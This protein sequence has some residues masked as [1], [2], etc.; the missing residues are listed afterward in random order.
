MFCV[1]R[2]WP[3]LLNEFY[4]PLKHN[5]GKWHLNFFNCWS[6]DCTTVWLEYQI[7]FGCDEMFS[8]PACPRV[9]GDTNWKHQES[10]WFGLVRIQC[11]C[12]VNLKPLVVLVVIWYCTTWDNMPDGTSVLQAASVWESGHLL[13]SWVWMTSHTTLILFWGGGGGCHPP[14]PKKPS[15]IQEQGARKTWAA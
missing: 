15:W 1:S 10:F 12:H 7:S 5:L 6:Y 13:C 11:M 14:T 9:A 2:Q 3:T 4:W 8:L